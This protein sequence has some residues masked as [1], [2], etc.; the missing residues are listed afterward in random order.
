[1]KL[2]LIGGGGVRGPLFVASCLARAERLGLD[3]VYLLDNRQD[4][5]DVIAPIAREIVRRSGVRL[6]L[7]ATT[8]PEV[9]IRDASYVVTTVRVGG[10]EARIRD[11]RIALARGVLGQETT[12]PGGFAMAA[13]TIPVALRYAEQIDRVAPRSW[14]FNFSN[15][16]G[17]VTQA[18]RD[19]G[20]ERV[21]GIC[22]GANAAQM[23]VAE[24]F[25]TL[26]EQ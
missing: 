18:L 24:S 26:A 3:E 20:H 17:L 8:D 5:L 7:V 6:S 10:D 11:E 9:A 16:A 12:G 19:A 4:H 15:P 21:I 2:A 13:R 14:T 1:M 22:D 25:D 23:H